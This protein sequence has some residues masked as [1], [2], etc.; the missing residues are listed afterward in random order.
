M[1]N[2]R[3]AWLCILRWLG[4]IQAKPGIVFNALNESLIGAAAE[5]ISNKQPFDSE[6]STILM[7]LH[8]VKH[9][10]FDGPVHFGAPCEISRKMFTV[11]GFFKAS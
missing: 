9:F 2:E 7:L 6:V 8:R 5:D 3:K 4:I 1:K 11:L 10:E